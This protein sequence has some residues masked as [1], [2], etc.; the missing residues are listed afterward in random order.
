MDLTTEEL[1]ENAILE[2]QS[3][4]AAR[5]VELDAITVS[6]DDGKGGELVFQAGK[7]SRDLMSQAVDAAV[8]LGVAVHKWKMAD[9]TWQTVT[10]DQLKKARA[11]GLQRHAEILAKYSI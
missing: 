8:T 4:K 10:L 3:K 2:R 6:V 5:Q 11:L 9:N 1:A 7:E